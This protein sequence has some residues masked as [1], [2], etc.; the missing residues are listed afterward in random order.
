MTQQCEAYPRRFTYYNQHVKPIRKLMACP[1]GESKGEVVSIRTSGSLSDRPHQRIARSPIEDRT[2]SATT[3]LH[4]AQTISTMWILID[5]VRRYAERSVPHSVRSAHLLGRNVID[6]YTVP[7]CPVV[8]RELD[9]YGDE[10][11]ALRKTAASPMNA[12]SPTER[13][14]SRDPSFRVMGR[15]QPDVSTK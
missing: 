1:T 4:R 2:A 12:A 9:R 6:E 15:L 7:V 5:C 8:H 10:A 3:S 13:V 11:S 14:H